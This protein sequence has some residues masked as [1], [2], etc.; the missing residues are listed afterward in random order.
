MCVVGRALQPHFGTG[1]TSIAL[2]VSRHNPSRVCLN[3]IFIDKATC[4]FLVNLG[5]RLIS[6]AVPFLVVS[7]WWHWPGFWC[8]ILCVL[9]LDHVWFGKVM[10]CLVLNRTCFG[11]ILN[12]TR[13]VPGILVSIT[14]F[15]AR[16][17]PS[18]CILVLIGTF[19]FLSSPGTSFT[20]GLWWGL[21]RRPSLGPT[22][23]SRLAS[24]NLASFELLEQPDNVIVC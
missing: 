1:N 20:I 12:R 4:A 10:E 23:G 15:E 2:L 17:P 11:E 5:L 16:T 13:I 9:R 19:A 6:L 24:P 7:F 3:V 8:Q 22:A 21:W 14:T 18:R